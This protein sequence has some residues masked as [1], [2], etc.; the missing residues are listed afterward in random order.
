M[1]TLT[2]AKSQEPARGRQRKSAG[3][4][5]SAGHATAEPLFNRN[6]TLLQQFIVRCLQNQNSN[7]HRSTSSQGPADARHR[8][9]LARRA[10]VGQL[11]ENPSHNYAKV[12]SIESL[13]STQRQQQ[14]HRTSSIS[15]EPRTARHTNVELWSASGGH[16]FDTPSHSSTRSQAPFCGRHASPS[17]FN[18]SAGHCADEPV[19]RSYSNTHMLLSNRFSLTMIV[20]LTSLSHRSV[21]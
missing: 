16:C 12:V 2:S 10:S 14:Q 6:K 19:H 1:H 21:A 20:E 3:L 7:L 9:P 13:L 8:N 18:V 5:V 15:Q 17:G 11:L 4:K